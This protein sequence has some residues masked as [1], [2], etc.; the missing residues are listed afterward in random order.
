MTDEFAESTFPESA[1]DHQADI[2]GDPPKDT[3]CERFHQRCG[4]Q[5]SFVFLLFFLLWCS[6]AFNDIIWNS[7]DHPFDVFIFFTGSGYLADPKPVYIIGNIIVWTLLIF[8]C[9][10]F[11]WQWFF[12][13]RSQ[14]LLVI[15][16]FQ[17]A[18]FLLNAISLVNEPPS[19]IHYTD[20]PLL[21][22]T[23]P[24]TMVA[25]PKPAIVL[26]AMWDFWDGS[27]W[28]RS[29]ITFLSCL[30]VV[31]LSA[32]AQMYSSPF[33]LSVC[34]L[35]AI[36]LRFQYSAA[37]RW[38]SEAVRLQPD[39]IGKFPADEL[40]NAIRLPMVNQSISYSESYPTTDFDDI[41]YPTPPP[42]VKVKGSG[43]RVTFT[44]VAEDEVEMTKTGNTEKV[45]GG[46]GMENGKMGGVGMAKGKM[47]GVGMAN[48]KMG[49][50][51][52]EDDDDGEVDELKKPI[53]ITLDSLLD[54]GKSSSGN[55]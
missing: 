44:V 11:L 27:R 10:Y 6:S 21:E 46:G 17:A 1:T 29:L 48:R 43:N 9:V 26:Y 52:S 35:A 16:W 32:T 49:G 47:G 54:V 24:G 31:Y 15:C 2:A 7:V 36:H 53:E 28:K 22:L 12:N 41:I 45:A 23:S 19:L 51:D 5:T 13:G 33:I 20:F 3:L 14:I 55:E 37:G 50:G 38:M 4:L 34:L 30:M 8:S 42:P 25:P 18:C 40:L 39:L